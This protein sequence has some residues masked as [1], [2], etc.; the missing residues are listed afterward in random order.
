MKEKRLLKAMGQVDKQYIE[1]AFSYNSSTR[2]TPQFHRLSAALIAAI[3]SVCLMGAGVATVIYGDHIQSWFGHCWEVIT[4]QPMSEEHLA[5]IEHLSQEIG[6]SQTV[7]N[8][9]ITV[10]SATVG[11]DNFFLLL[12][13]DGMNFSNKYSY[14]FQHVRME[15]KPDPLKDGAFVGYGIDYLGLDGDG[16]PLLLLNY[17]YAGSN[18]YMQDQDTRPLEVWLTLQ[19]LVKDAYTDNQETLLEGDWYFSFVIDRSQSPEVI[20]LPDT[21]VMAMDLDTHEEIPIIVTN[22]ELTNTGL[23][24]QYT[25]EEGTLSLSNQG[26][27]VV[28]EN[29]KVIGNNG[30]IGSPTEDNL[31][32]KYS[33]QWL[34]P[35]NLNEVATILI[36]ETEVYVP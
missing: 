12:R 3:L 20:S 4:G 16:I 5:V 21:E 30:G 22:I 1:E 32:M 15:T 14:D 13:V 26:I 19:N 35:V 8:V 29:G 36:G 10:D 31:A 11:D 23:R 9:T 7:G 24:L 33:C 6:V 18:G 17:E 25:H 34:V 27:K 28:L 2:H